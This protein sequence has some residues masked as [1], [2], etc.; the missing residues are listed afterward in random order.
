MRL[1]PAVFALF[2][3][4][5]ALAQ[6]VP[7][8]QPE[9]RQPAPEALT[10]PKLIAPA[11]AAYPQGAS[12]PARVVVQMDVDERG[13][14][15]NLVVQGA[16]Q[17]G[18]DEAALAA[19]AQMRFEPA[20]RGGEP[21]AVRIQSAFNFSPPPTARE[22]AAAAPVNFSGQIRERGSRRKLAGIEVSA[23]GKSGFT[24]KDGRFELRGLPEG[25]PVEVVIAAPGYQRLVASETI[26]GG[27]K[28]E[29]EYRLQP[30]Y[31]SPLEATVEG[32]RERTE[33]SRTSV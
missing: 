27:G 5:P 13:V 11:D 2:C 10:P 16:P 7:D 9:K 15:G 19:A 30:L 17:P 23:A 26:P 12:G 21:I 6:P 28:L 29:V 22:Q 24:D 18:F 4:A 14:P 3:A 33:L 31:A 1:P 32:E 25:A 8:P 20:R